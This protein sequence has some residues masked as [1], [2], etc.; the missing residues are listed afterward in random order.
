MQI[1]LPSSADVARAIKVWSSQDARLAQLIT[2]YGDPAPALR[3]F[4]LVLW[5]AGQMQTASHVL[6][7][8]A[9][10]KPDD[11]LVWNDLSSVFSALGQQ[12]EAAACS[13]TSLARD[14]S[15]APIWARLGAIRSA[16]GDGPKSIDAF[17]RALQLDA[18]S[19]DARVGL[20][21]EYLRAKRFQEAAAAFE[22]AIAHGMG[23]DPAIRACLGEAL[24]AIGDFVGAAEAFAVASAALPD[25]DA[26][27][28]KHARAVCAVDVIGGPVR[29]AVL[30]FE[31]QA[32]PPADVEKALHDIFHLL[33]AHQHREAAIRLGTFRLARTP[34]DIAQTYLLATLKQEPIERAPDAYI[35]SFFDKFADGFDQQLVDVLDYRVPGQLVA[36]IEAAARPVAT[37]LDIG[38][39]T[40]L[41][42]ALLA[43]SGRV[44]VGVDL[45]PRM[46]DKARQIGCYES[47]VEAEVVAFLATNTTTHDLV[48]AA[49]VL[50]Y[51]GDLRQIFEG[52]ARA[53]KPGGL[54]A[55][56]IETTDGIDISH[57]TS[58]RFAHGLDYVR[59]EAARAG[60]VILANERTRIRLD[61]G[62]PAHGALLL[63]SKT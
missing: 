51:F 25:N 54:W 58:G 48:I 47:L 34:D 46:L 49:D 30:T 44:L 27:R 36:L 50:I 23:G 16:L 24:Y 26:L 18:T 14:P 55:L 60:F 7:G 33:S 4:G 62:T 45:S 2:R 21:L 8:A 59:R 41:A 6:S 57:L 37:I 52:V 15:Q 12:N 35:V 10:L 53:L 28:F 40:G 39:G 42:G 13:E 31:G 19:T 5:E 38:C 3:H 56:S 63:L 29:D 20:G 9:T 1:T 61:A 32:L 11:P 43:R 22:D 17:V